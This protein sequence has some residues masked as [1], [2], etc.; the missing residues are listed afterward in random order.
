MSAK[1]KKV[2][3]FRVPDQ[4]RLHALFEA[5]PDQDKRLTWLRT[6]YPDIAAQFE[7]LVKDLAEHTLDVLMTNLAGRQTNLGGQ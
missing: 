7:K 1:P 6:H 5:T 3:R 2:I 4:R